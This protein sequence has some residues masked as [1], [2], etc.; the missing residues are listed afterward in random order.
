LVRVEWILGDKARGGI[1]VRGRRR[2]QA[3]LVGAA[4]LGPLAGPLP[5]AAAAEPTFSVAHLPPGV[6]LRGEKVLLHVQV[7][8]TDFGTPSGAAFVRDDPHAAFTRLRLFGQDGGLRARRVP[9]RFLD[10]DVFEDFV[11]VH[12]SGTG[13]TLRVPPTGSYRSWIRGSV[14]TVDLGLHRFGNVRRP[15]AI[16]ARA[17]PGDGP[18]EAGFRCEPDGV[19]LGPSSFDVGAHGRVWV[20]DDVHDRLLG[21]DPGRP[22]QPIRSI[23]LPFFPADVALGLDGTLYVSGHRVGGGPPRLYAYTQEGV[24]LW[25]ELLLAGFADDF[26]RLGPDGV[27]YSVDPFYGWVPVTDADEGPLTIAEQREGVRPYEPVA[28]DLQLF[29]EGHFA[30]HRFRLALATESG[31]LHRAWEISS[32]SPLADRSDGSPSTAGG[33]PVLLFQVFD[34]HAHLEEHLVVRLSATDG[35]RTKLSTSCCAFGETVVTAMRV[36]PDGKLYQLLTSPQTGLR[37]ARYALG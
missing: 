29:E 27:V 8:T 31:H 32:A 24:R 15:G 7:Q 37:I 22:D 12:D 26:I 6:I 21:W 19:C 4:L 18:G 20:V 25:K 33:D 9:D 16:V 13:K 28:S 11:V 17:A 34:L 23:A 35:V 1:S 30:P 14:H 2:V 3:L 5:R 36:G 10:G